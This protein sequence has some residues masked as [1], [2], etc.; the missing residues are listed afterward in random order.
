MERQMPHS[1]DIEQAVLGA[2]MMYASAVREAEDYGL[3]PADF[4]EERHARIYE[5]VMQL[6]KEGRTV[7]ITTLTSRLEDKKLLSYVGGVDYLF[8]LTQKATSSAGVKHHIA[9]LI[10]KAHTRNLI[11]AAQLI[12]EEG[13]TQS[14][15]LDEYISNAEKAILNVTRSRMVND[16]R[17]SEEVVD[18]VIQ[19]TIALSEAKNAV[20]GLPTGYEKFDQLTNGLHSGDLLILAARP[21]VGKSAFAL[22]LARQC[23]KYSA[24]ENRGAVALFSL[25]MPST[26]LI[27]RMLSSE[28]RINS[29]KIQSGKLN[30][31][32]WSRLHYGA[33]QLKEYPLF[34]DDS[35]VIRVNEIFAKCR[36]LKAEHGLCLI[37]IDYLQL[38][39]GSGNKGDNRQLEISEISRS[40]KQLAREMEVPVIALSQLSRN[41]EKREDKRP[42]LSD[43]RESGA[44]EQDADIVMFLH[45]EDY[46]TKDAGEVDTVKVE[47]IFAKHRNGATGSIEL[48]FTKSISKFD[49]YS[50]DM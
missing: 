18:E 32:D 43:L 10:E 19:E 44:I 22:N 47:V 5:A 12:A 9:I 7:D 24:L 25:E 21:S 48:A 16:F 31:E 28:S 6:Y 36:K 3:K 49:N 1:I 46:Q 8:Q 35:S 38:I 4:Y 29:Y 13:L 40:L 17:S 39:T 37:I 11:S 23:A 45:R 26:Q 30:N 20:T 42:M 15:T 50:D 41:V 2:Q 34:L 14:S 33:N 27:K